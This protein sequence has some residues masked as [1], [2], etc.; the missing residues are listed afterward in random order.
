MNV[1]TIGG[2]MVDTIVTI[3]SDKIEQIKMR[4]AESSFLLLEEGHKTEAEQIAASCGGGA[5]NAAVA[6]RALA[7]RHPSSQIGRD[8]KGRRYSHLLTAEGIECFVCRR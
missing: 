1:L 6:A 8:D 7:T 3:A 5:M 2:A 4:N